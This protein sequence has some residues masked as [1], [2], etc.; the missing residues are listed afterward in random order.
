VLVQVLT[1]HLERFERATNADGDAHAPPRFVL[2]ALRAIAGCSD[3]S[4]GFLRFACDRCR[5]PRIVPFSCKASL[6]P[7]CGARRMADL[8]AHAVDRVLPRVPYRQWVVSLPFA[9]RYAVAFD[10]DLLNAVFACASRAIQETITALGA[11]AG[12][13]G[14]P[15]GVLH[16]QRFQ[17][18]LGVNPHG[19]YVLSDA[20]FTAAAAPDTHARVTWTRAP[21]RDDLQRTVNRIER[22]VIR[23]LERRAK[24][25]AADSGVR[26]ILERLA[27][28]APCAEHR[29]PG[30]R[31][32]HAPRRATP[33][34]C[35]RSDAGF[36]LH[37]GVSLPAHDRAALERL[38]RY[39][40]R[41]PLGA[42][43]LSRRANGNV[44]L[45]LRR[46]SARGAYAIEYTPLAFMARLAALVPA[47][48]FVA[49]RNLGAIAPHA[50]IRPTVLPTTPENT[51]ERKTAPERPARL[52]WA[53]LMKRVL[54]IDP[55]DC[56]CGGRFR[57]VSVIEEPDLIQAIA[58]AL[59]ASGHLA[60]HRAPRGPPRHRPRYSAQRRAK[61]TAYQ[62]LPGEDAG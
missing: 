35:A 20:V 13:A 31:A 42:D 55:K 22:D 51:P 8:A 39:L 29:L 38:L 4:R 24:D 27:R 44:V 34:L 60:P 15:A 56:P 16:I 61:R 58:A 2:D 45:T 19:H 18:D 3:L 48:R 46:A 26:A 1:E 25:D 6:C 37:A 7:S 33:P 50:T 10:A 11:E 49:M 43:R 17:S 12:A 40:A 30:D 21:T 53:N 5:A 9:L 23:L 41:P 57:L 54:G 14:Q 28:A 32:G 52:D 47:P 62:H 36:D 59:I